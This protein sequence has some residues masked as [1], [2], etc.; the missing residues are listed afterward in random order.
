MQRKTNEKLNTMV[1]YRN[2]KWRRKKG[3]TMEKIKSRIEERRAESRIIF[4]SEIRSI[5]EASTSS[6]T[7]FLTRRPSTLTWKM[8]RGVQSFREKEMRTMN[9]EIE[10]WISRATQFPRVS[11][12]KIS[13]ERR[14]SNGFL[15]N[16][17]DIELT[18][19]YFFFISN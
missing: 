3:G 11:S 10:S 4:Q 19:R 7:R 16:H 2:V 12:G 13:G 6:T 8:H 9:R 5:R 17:L 14:F 18:P 1:K 15:R